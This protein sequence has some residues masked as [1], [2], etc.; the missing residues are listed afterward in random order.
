MCAT[1]D[2]VM[3]RCSSEVVPVQKTLK[4]LAA[5]L[6]VIALCA[7]L[8]FWP[9]DDA[10]PSGL[11]VSTATVTVPATVVVPTTASPLESTTTVSLPEPAPSTTTTTAP[12]QITVAAVGD[13]LTHMPIV[14][15]VRNRSNGSYEFGPIF[16]PIAPYLRAADYA[17]ANLE[18]RLAGPEA[19]YSGYP[20]FNTPGEL[21]YVLKDIGIDLVATAN[22]H[23]LDMG[24]D[25]LVRTLDKLDQ[26][27][28]SHAGTH[29]TQE[30]RRV[31]L[32]VDIQG[33]RVAFLNYTATL[34]G[35]VIPEEHPYAVDV[36]DVDRVA[37][38]A[39]TARLYG[40]EVVIAILHQGNEYDREP[41]EKQIEI[42]RK[43][44]SQGVDVIL[45]SHPHVVQPISHI[46]EYT[47][48]KVSDKYI[49]YSLGNFI[50]AQR[51][52]YSDSGIVAYVHIEKR[53][54][55]AYVTGISYL[56]VYVQVGMLEG[57]QSYRV[58]PVLPGLE[59]DTD[60]P[61]TPADRQRMASVWEELRPLL[62]SPNEGISVLSLGELRYS[63][64]R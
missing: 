35:L 13:V 55:R 60:I 33:I 14:Y 44:L 47:G 34:N 63:G 62:F 43:L 2:P 23:A 38:D 15:S 7:P 1:C 16:A 36:L 8:I 54:L 59:P 28:L 32:V 5:A 4:A 37:N 19:G 25:G 3:G 26:A 50:S 17:V 22:N 42:S 11:Q 49:V 30:E 20:R 40:A 31:P 64:V 53:G 41:S 52:R 9:V 10:E 39:A 45:G 21:A 27:Q 58:V 57:R 61:L 48:W 56:P 24:W 46:F 6:A 51:W 29:R 18:T 12:V